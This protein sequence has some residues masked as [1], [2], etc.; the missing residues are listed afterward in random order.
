MNPLSNFASAERTF[1][2]CSSRFMNCCSTVSRNLLRIRPCDGVADGNQNLKAS[3]DQNTLIDGQVNLA[4]R[5]GLVDENP[6]R[7]S[8]GA[9]EP[10]RQQAERALARLSHDTGHIGRLGEDCKGQQNLKR[11]ERR[12]HFGL[13]R[14][15][16]R[17]PV[18]R[19]LLAYLLFPALPRSAR[20][21]RRRFRGYP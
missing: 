9:V 8:G 2:S 17:A 10:V 14:R 21:C 5:R 15:F 13:P 19:K 18:C 11:D 12:R 3:L 4:F 16:V 20:S 6:W 1:C 7:Q